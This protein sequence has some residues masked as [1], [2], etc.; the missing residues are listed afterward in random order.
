MSID[1]D[2]STIP[3]D[4]RQRVAQ[5]V[6]NS[7]TGKTYEVFQLQLDISISQ[8]R[9]DIGLMCGKTTGMMGHTGVN[10]FPLGSCEPIALS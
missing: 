4:V 2:L 9:A 3:P 1:F 5:T 8:E 10:G 7:Q 6:S